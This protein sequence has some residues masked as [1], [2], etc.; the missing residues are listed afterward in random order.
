LTEPELILALKEKSE[1]AFKELV[2]LYQHRVFNTALSLLQHPGDAEDVAQEV[3]MQVYRSI[4]SFKEQSQLSTWIYRITVTRSLDHLRAKKRK[5][6]FGIIGSHA[7]RVHP[8]PARCAANRF[9]FEQGR[10]FILP[11]NCSHHRYFG[12]SR[13]RPAAKGKAKF[14]KND[15]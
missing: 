5:K 12:K 7:F 6:R 13:G 9:Y 10:R 2:N 11:R 3:F 8:P 14:K 1:P 4:N 15:K